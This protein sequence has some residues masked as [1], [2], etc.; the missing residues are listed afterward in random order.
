MF[1]VFDGVKSTVG[2]AENEE[3]S[4]RFKACVIKRVEEEEEKSLNLN[5]SMRETEAEGNK[6]NSYE[7]CV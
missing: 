1:Y 4:T 6:L 3:E 5:P 2:K 7:L